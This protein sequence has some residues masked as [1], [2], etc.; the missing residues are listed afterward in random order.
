MIV[1]YTAEL[2]AMVSHAANKYNKEYWDN[3]PAFMTDLYSEIMDRSEKG[4]TKTLFMTHNYDT[5][6]I[7]KAI[8]ILKK[9]GYRVVESEEYDNSIDISWA[10]L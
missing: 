1:K 4:H 3:Q 10:N 6:T 8:N 9:D 7:N 2:A 5:K